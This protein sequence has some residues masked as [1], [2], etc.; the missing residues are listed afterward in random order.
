M[1]GLPSVTGASPL[2]RTVASLPAPV[3]LAFL[4]FLFQSY[5]PWP[6]APVWPARCNVCWCSARTSE[7][8]ELQRQL[9][10]VRDS[11][12]KRLAALQVGLTRPYP[13]QPRVRVRLCACVRA[14]V[15][16]YACLTEP[17]PS[18]A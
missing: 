10:E 16:M 8:A 15:C 13:T 5:S 7:H 6:V 4:H 2:D 11:A 18:P 3:R 17:S 14:R 12:E 1:L 9:A